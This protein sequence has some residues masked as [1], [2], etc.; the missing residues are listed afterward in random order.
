[1]APPLMEAEFP[2]IVQLV[3]VGE[4]SL[5]YIAPPELAEFPEIVQ[6]VIEGEVE[7]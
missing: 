7:E 1:M 6:L 5:L 4:E 2:E 3:M